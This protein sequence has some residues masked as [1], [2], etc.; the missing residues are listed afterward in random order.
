MLESSG[1]GTMLRNKCIAFLIL[2]S[3]GCGGRPSNPG[4]EVVSH[5]PAE[6]NND[7]FEHVEVT[8]NGVDA[9][10]LIPKLTTGDNVAVRA[11]IVRNDKSI[12]PAIVNLHVR[13]L[14]E[15]SPE[16][17]WESF[18]FDDEFNGTI[19]ILSGQSTFESVIRATPGR[20]D[21]RCY[22][23]YIVATEEK[24]AFYLLG[25]G[26]AEVTEGRKEPKASAH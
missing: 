12:I 18:D 14:P 25:K 26:K 24:P 4:Y 7:A 11:R 13:L 22:A 16:E 6:V 15:G 21:V 3:F 19:D 20:F 17:R 5:P 8:L 2:W 10:T 1:Q 9:F 23:L